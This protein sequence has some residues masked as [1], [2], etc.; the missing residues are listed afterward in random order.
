MS[1]LVNAFKTSKELEIKGVVRDFGFARIT[2]ARAGGANQ[3]FNMIM[4]RIYRENNR[5]IKAGL[6]SNEKSMKMLHEAYAEA[7][8]LNWETNIGEDGAEE[9]KQGIELEEGIVPFTKENIIRAF[10]DLPALFLEVKEI[11]EDIQ[12][13]RASLLEGV[14]KN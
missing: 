1:R 3:K 5:A 14:T 2:V 11:A 10:N 8:V 13:Y 4:E 9:W 7:I 6:L 12:F